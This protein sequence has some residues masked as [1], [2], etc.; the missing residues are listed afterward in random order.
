MASL[1]ALVLGSSR[2]SLQSKSQNR[3]PLAAFGLKR[4]TR[5]NGFSRR[6]SIRVQAI[7]APEKAT[8]EP[9]SAWSTAIE[10]IP[11][12][13]DLKT[14]MILGAGP[15]VIGQVRCRE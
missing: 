2:P 5:A 13:T 1:G 8:P 3:L 14:I 15:I 9:F 6:A 10:R 11:K 4:F 7:A 12:R